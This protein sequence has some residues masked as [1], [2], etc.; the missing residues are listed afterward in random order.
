MP[1]S[2]LISVEA[3]ATRLGVGRSTMYRWLDD[4]EN[5]PAFFVR[6]GARWKV[7]IPLLEKHLGA[8]A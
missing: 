4:K 2:D 3:A 1:E 7:S 6:V 8:V 5:R